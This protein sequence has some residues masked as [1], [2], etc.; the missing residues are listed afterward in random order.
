MPTVFQAA[1]RAYRRNGAIPPRADLAALAGVSEATASRHV[2]EAVAG[3]LLLHPHRGVYTPRWPSVVTA[4]AVGIGAALAALP[5][6]ERD[7][8]RGELR[9]AL[10]EGVVVEAVEAAVSSLAALDAVLDPSVWADAYHDDG[11]FEELCAR[12]EAADKALETLR[13][14]WG[15]RLRG[16]L[17]EVGATSGREGMARRLEEAAA[18]LDAATK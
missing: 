1:L 4:P 9:H 2:E 3:G 14:G 11:L 12:T 8:A 18:W 17:D 13:V 10:P 15:W 7:S 5:A 16:G 6:R